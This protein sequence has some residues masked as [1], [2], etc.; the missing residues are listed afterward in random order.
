MIP[1]MSK[2]IILLE[3]FTIWVLHKKQQD[4][5]AEPCEFG[6]EKTESYQKLNVNVCIVLLVN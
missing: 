2:T 4:L 3:K 5:L 6:L 1:V